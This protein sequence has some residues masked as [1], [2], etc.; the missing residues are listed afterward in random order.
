MEH[1]TITTLENGYVRLTPEAGYALLNII[2][3]ATYSEAVVKDGH[4]GKF[5]AIPKVTTL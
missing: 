5:V 2:T 3:R 1:I 4:K